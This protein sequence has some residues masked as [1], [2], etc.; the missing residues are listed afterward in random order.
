MGATLVA[1]LDDYEIIE[2]AQR[3]MF[4]GLDG[5]GRLVAI[6]DQMINTLIDIHNFLQSITGFGTLIGGVSNA[7]LKRTDGFTAL[8]F[9]RGCLFDPWLYAQDEAYQQAA[10]LGIRKA[11]IAVQHRIEY[12][13]KNA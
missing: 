7:P 9:V 8:P 3:V 10:V 4:R 1:L 2:R 11:Q 12:L 5:T 6:N 13:V